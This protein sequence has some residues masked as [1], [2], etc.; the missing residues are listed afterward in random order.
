[1]KNYS[2]INQ[3]KNDHLKISSQKDV[4]SSNTTELEKFRLIHNA[5][6]EIDL[7]NVDTSLTIF[8]KTIS[9]PLM[10][11]SMTGGTGKA[12]EINQIL[13]RSAQSRSRFGPDA[14]G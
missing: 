10:I 9:L 11:S 7:S 13:A 4:K 14:R 6:P 8:N 5:L 1:M 2:T 3:R 12:H